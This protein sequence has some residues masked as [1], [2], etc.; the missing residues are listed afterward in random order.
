MKTSWR[1]LFAVVVTIVF[2]FSVNGYSEIGD[3]P[4]KHKRRG[5]LAVKIRKCPQVVHPGEDLGSRFKVIAKSR[6]SHAINNVTVDIILSSDTSYPI[7][8]PYAIY[9][10]NYSEDVLLQGGREHISFS[11]PGRQRVTLNGNNKI[12]SDTPP[13]RYYLGAVIDAGNKVKEHN[14]NNNVAFCQVIVQASND[15]SENLPN[16]RIRFDHRDSGGRV[17]I[18]VVNWS[19]YPDEMFR[20]SPELPPCG[21]NTSASRTWVE[22]FDSDTNRYLYGFCALYSSSGLKNIWVKPL[23]DNIRSVY[24]IMKDRVCQK[25]YRS[26]SISIQ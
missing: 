10:P 9:S 20:P 13:G 25:E 7:P 16:P 19:D 4:L 14:E 26:N 6:F 1:L 8:A 2:C 15:C 24:I 22:I 3:A 21:L 18:P 23:H 17:Y 11:G 12:P 5:D